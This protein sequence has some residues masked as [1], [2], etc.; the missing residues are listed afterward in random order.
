MIEELKNNV[1]LEI[2][3][4]REI[5]TNFAQAEG[6]SEKE[7]VLL[8]AAIESLQKKMK[9]IN[10]ALP[11]II[12]NISPLQPLGAAVKPT[13]L[14][15]M[16]ITND[17]GSKTQV[18]LNKK[19]REKFMK[20]HDL[21]NGFLKRLKKE[22][23]EE[24]VAKIEFK[25]ARG[26]VKLSNRFFLGYAQKMTEND[27]LSPVG[28][29]IKKGNMD[30][31]FSS[32]IS[33]GLMSAALSIIVG[34]FFTLFF[35]F[36]NLGLDIPFVFAYSGSF[37]SRLLI[38]IWL[39]LVF[40]ILTLAAFYYYPS[41]EKSSIEKKIDQE[42][43]FAVIHMSAISGSGIEPSEIFKIIGLSREYPALRKEIRKIINEINF[44]GYDLVT[45]LNYVSKNTPSTKLA[46]LLSG[47]STTI[48]SGGN[49]G[50]FFE[51]R[52]ESLLMSYRLE[53][54]KFTKIA[55]TFMDIY[56][57]VAI[58]A[59]LLFMLMLVIM[60]VWSNGIGL[61]TSQLGVLIML[62]IAII[63]VFF[64]GFLHMK[65]PAY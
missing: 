46:E 38:V 52:A 36:F 11:E 37:L 47:L 61:T 32:Y 27:F 55:E 4:L 7:K 29:D 58:A 40:P 51:K 63:N 41:T 13:T 64:I 14:Q 44:Y 65:Q 59:P 1:N 19:D 28:F 17:N 20:E 2:A 62:A 33:M 22:R 30:I 60:Q 39:P 56:I 8:A 45:A 34:M 25:G 49:L 53:R 6:T 42:L 10:N 18:I 16:E 21:G 12:K 23:V 57:S 54:E 31:L 3:I 15:K 43:P 26:Y 5:S 50:T 48:T 35:M 9:L 24:N